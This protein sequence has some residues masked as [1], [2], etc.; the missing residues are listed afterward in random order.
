MELEIHSMESLSTSLLAEWESLARS[1]TG[2]ANPFLVPAWAIH[3]CRVWSTPQDSGL[4]AMLDKG[5]LVGAMPVHRQVVTLA[6]VPFARRLLPVGSGRGSL[7][8]EL[9]QVLCAVGHER[10]VTR[11]LVEELLARGRP[12]GCDWAEITIPAAHGWFE[13]EW[14]YTAPRP[15]FYHLLQSRPACVL[16][17]SPTWEETQAGLGKNIKESIRRSRNRVAK[18]AADMQLIEYGRD[19]VVLDVDAVDRFLTLHRQRAHMASGVVHPDNYSAPADFSFMRHLLP[20]LAR[21]GDASILELNLRGRPIASQLVLHAPGTVYLHSS[22][23]D[24]AFASLG[25]VLHLQVE[26]I[27]RAITRGAAWVNF[28]PGITVSKM[29]WGVSTAP[30]NDFAFGVTGEGRTERFRVFAA[31]KAAKVVSTSVKQTSRN[32]APAV[33]EPSRA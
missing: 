17:L 26:A 11:R 12:S 21:A 7:S 27:R 22:G 15:A 29:R 10:R 8:L 5:R 28:S 14:A 3:W 24:E 19:G 33:V 30:Y 23:L 1:Q 16:L 31:A 4:I 25:P 18:H 9:P 6:G 32:K 2:P 13:P 20:E